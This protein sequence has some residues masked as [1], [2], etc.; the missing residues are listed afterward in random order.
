MGNFGGLNDVVSPYT[1]S[2]GAQV[3]LC[4]LSQW[5][6]TSVSLESL[7]CGRRMCLLIRVP[8][9]LPDILK[10]HSV[11]LFIK[12]VLSHCYSPVTLISSYNTYLF[13]L[14]V[15]KV[16]QYPIYSFM[17]RGSA[18]A[19]WLLIIDNLEI[20]LLMASHSLLL[21][22]SWLDSNQSSME[23]GGLLVYRGRKEKP[24]I[25]ADSTQ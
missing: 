21:L 19:L 25:P 8:V 6:N 4:L 20:P 7:T 9:F 15:E 1:F 3:K 12:I 2:W 14:S 23:I 24:F 18:L 11:D 13:L 22:P 10:H 16:W 17:E 5:R